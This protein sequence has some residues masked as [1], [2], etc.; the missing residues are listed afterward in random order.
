MT[1]PG[2][3][4]GTSCTDGPFN[5]QL[6]HPCSFKHYIRNVWRNSYRVLAFEVENHRDS[7]A[8]RQATLGIIYSIDQSINQSIQSVN[9][10][11]NQSLIYSINQSIIQ[12]IN[13]S[14]NHPINQSITHLFNQSLIYS[15][16]QPINHLFIQSINQSINQ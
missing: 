11:I 6:H 12:S 2:I 1:S 8:C 4:L 9:Q 16:N 15:F 13:H 7:R 14:I 10:S 3:E 5:N